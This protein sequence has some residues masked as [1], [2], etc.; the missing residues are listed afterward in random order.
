MA[1]PG[2][3]S[4]K[5]SCDHVVSRGFVFDLEE[6]A[7]GFQEQEIICPIC[8]SKGLYSRKNLVLTPAPSIHPEG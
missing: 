2:N 3:V 5:L 6:W 8:E 7:A 1:L 4:V